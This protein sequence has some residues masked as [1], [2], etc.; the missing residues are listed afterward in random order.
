MSYQWDI[1]SFH[2]VL[3]TAYN[4]DK[5]YLHSSRSAIQNL[6]TIINIAASKTYSFIH[7]ARAGG[8]LLSNQFFS[9]EEIEAVSIFLSR[10]LIENKEVP[11]LQDFY[12]QIAELGGYKN[13]TNK[14]P[15]GVLTIYRGMQKLQ[16][17]TDMYK[18]MVS[19]K[20]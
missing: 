5:V 12:Y 3:K 17:I 19:I 15:P 20:T 13:K 1:E 11:N 2:K 6:L 7:Q 18:A 16:N 9:L 14:H 4:A 8:D 10:K